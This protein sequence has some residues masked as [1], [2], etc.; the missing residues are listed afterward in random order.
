MTDRD[1]NGSELIDRDALNRRG[2]EACV[3]PGAGTFFEA[4]EQ[5]LRRR[6]L[7]VPFLEFDLVGEIRGEPRPVTRVER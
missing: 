7:D 3:T 5:D 1:T 4:L 6:H 2:I